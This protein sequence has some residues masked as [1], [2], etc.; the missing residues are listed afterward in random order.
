MEKAEIIRY[1]K[2]MSSIPEKFIDELFEFYDY[3][4]LQTDM[5]IDLDRVANWFEIK[6]SVLIKTLKE[7]YKNNIDYVIRKE[8]N[9][10]KKNSFN[11]N[12]KRVLI[13]PDCFK[14]LAMA[15]RSKK[16]PTIRMYF[17]E[18]ENLF[19]K[20][21]RQTLLGMEQEIG[22]LERNM[23]PAKFAREGYIYVIRAS[24][25]RDSV[26][27]IGRSKDL[28]ARLRSHRSA[29]ADD[30]E[31]VYIYHT[32]DIE[33]IEKCTHLWLKKFQYRKYREVFQ[34]NLQIIKEIIQSCG[35]TG[36]IVMKLEEKLKTKNKMTGGLYMITERQ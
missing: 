21:R 14:Q 31:V 22:T 35:S 15:T 8:A 34:I 23:K 33:A 10:N 28:Q 26:Y 24:E 25:T 36:K 3:D 7:S 32:N 4:S 2:Q 17:I 13:T 5:I 16:G 27:K 29:L 18:I 12:Y 11:N 9:P 19:I 6:K 30:F 1:I 20:Y